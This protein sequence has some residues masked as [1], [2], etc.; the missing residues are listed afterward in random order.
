M[1]GEQGPEYFNVL[2]EDGTVIGRT[3]N[4][5]AQCGNSETIFTNITIA[6]INQSAGSNSLITFFL[7]PNLVEGQP[8]RF[9]VNDICGGSSVEATLSFKTLIPQDIRYEYQINEGEKVTIYTPFTHHSSTTH[10]R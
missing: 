2:L 8:G 9:S 4:T 1:D 7:V 3:N 10:R 6:Q 5:P